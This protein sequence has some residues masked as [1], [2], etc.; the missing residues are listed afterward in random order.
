MT[1]RTDTARLLALIPYLRSHPGVAVTEVA[2]VF[3]V[4]TDRVIADLK[5]LWMVGLPG[6]MPDDLIDIDMDAVDSDG[7]ITITNADALPRPMRLTPDE[8]WSLLAALQV[9][10]DLADDTVRPAV[11]SAVEKLRQVCP[12]AG[13]DPVEAS[14]EA[15]YDPR[16]EWFTGACA[17]KWRIEIVHRRGDDP[18]PHTQI[19]DPVRAEVRDGH[20]YLV[21]WSMARKQWRTWRLDRIVTG[22]RVGH[23]TNHGRPPETLEWFSD[24]VDEVTLTLAPRAG[25]VAEYHPVRHVE[26]DGDMWKVTFAVAS[27]TWLAELMVG[28]GPDVLSVDPPHAAAPALQLARAAAAANGIEISNREAVEKS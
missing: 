11:E 2:R 27:A 28:L 17:N 12:Q 16:S 26:K 4:S 10:A 23:A 7:T 14:L 13:P 8:A 3:G 9:I 6:G 18:T 21:G 25:W 5:I 1:A 20:R 22:R 15:D 19:V 24:V